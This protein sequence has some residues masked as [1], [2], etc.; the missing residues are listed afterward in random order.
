MNAIGTQLGEPINSGLNQWRLTVYCVGAIAVS[1]SNP[2]SASTR[3]SLSVE[4]DKGDARRGGQ[5]CLARLNPQARTGTGKKM[6]SLFSRP[7]KKRIGNHILGG[8]ANPSRCFSVSICRILFFSFLTVPL[9]VLLLCWVFL[10]LCGAFVVLVLVFL[11]GLSS[12]AYYYMTVNV[13][14]T[15][16]SCV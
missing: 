8:A 13:N 3:F 2:A 12:A 11:P 10:S 4:N 9:P 15:S 5:T 6:K 14:V 16:L 1:G 7:H